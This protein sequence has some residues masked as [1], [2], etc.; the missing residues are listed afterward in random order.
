[1][2]VFLKHIYNNCEDWGIELLPYDNVIKLIYGFEEKRLSNIGID[3]DGG[4]ITDI[5]IYFSNGSNDERFYSE[6]SMSIFKDNKNYYLR[7]IKKHFSYNET[8]GIDAIR[9]IIGDHT[10][11]IAN[12]YIEIGKIIQNHTDT[13][14]FPFFGGGKVLKDN[15]VCGYKLYYTFYSYVKS[16]AKF[17]YIDVQNTYACILELL[18]HFRIN[19]SIK[20]TVISILDYYKNKAV[21]TLLG[22]NTDVVGYEEYKLYFIIPKETLEER[23]NN[24]KR[25]NSLLGNDEYS[26]ASGLFID[27]LESFD[28]PSF[29][30]LELCLSI[31]NNKIKLKSYFRTK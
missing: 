12:R 20:K 6:K 17:G 19:E 31:N 21:I 10:T 26:E 15:K 18:L 9:K 28:N 29:M 16:G 25:I 22:I 7:D 30:P 11:I 13:R 1:M 4:E 23:K 3:I 27:M 14:V 2:N 5:K 24:L 8:D